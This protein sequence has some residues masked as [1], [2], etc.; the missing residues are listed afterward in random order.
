[1]LRSTSSLTPWHLTT[2]PYKSISISYI[3]SSHKYAELVLWA[4]FIWLHILSKISKHVASI[5]KPP[6]SAVLNFFFL[7]IY[8]FFFKIGSYYEAWADLKFILLPQ[9]AQCCHLWY[10]KIPVWMERH[11]AVVTSLDSLESN[12]LSLSYKALWRMGPPNTLL[13]SKVQIYLVVQTSL[14]SLTCQHYN[15]KS[16]HL[17]AKCLIHSLFSHLG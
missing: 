16:E 2:L 11:K 10:C 3:T 9:C 6:S 7:L 8:L 13:Q 4:S 1:M 14:G 15:S 17:R 12:P 5:M